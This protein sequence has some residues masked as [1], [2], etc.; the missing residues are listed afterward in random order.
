MTEAVKRQVFTPF[1]TTKDVGQ[2]TGARPCGRSRHRDGPRRPDLAGERCR[3][4]DTGPILPT[5]GHADRKAER[6]S[7]SMT[8]PP[9]ARSHPPRRRF[10]RIPWGSGRNLA[11]RGLTVITAPGAGGHRHPPSGSVDLLITDV[12]MPGMSGTELLRL[13]RENYP[14]T[15]VMLITGYATIEGAVEAVKTGAE[16]YLSKPF[17]TGGALRRRRPG[18]GKAPSSPLPPGGETGRCIWGSL[19]RPRP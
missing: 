6:R 10:A 9:K 5:P 14:E 7:P 18:P 1:F 15:Q 8:A 19:A 3:K 16:E 4:G 17:T 11:E 12:K 13:V 2:G